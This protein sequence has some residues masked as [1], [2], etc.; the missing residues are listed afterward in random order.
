MF[1]SPGHRIQKYL[2]KHPETKVILV[3]GS[4]G[5]TSAI[6]AITSILTKS[7]NVSIGINKNISPDIVVLDFR[8]MQNFPLIKPDFV[9]LTSCYSK[10]ELEYYKPWIQESKYLFYNFNDIDKEVK[11]ELSQ[12]QNSFTYGDERPANFYFENQDSSLHGFKGSFVDPEDDRIA[13]FV[14]LLGE[15]NLR[16]VSLAAGIARSFKIPREDIIK[17]IESLRPLRGRM[18]PAEGPN[19]STIIDDSA[20]L[21]SISIKNGVHTISMLPAASRIVVIKNIR[22]K[23]PYDPDLIH[24]IVIIDPDI[25]VPENG[26]FH[27]FKTEIEAIK[28]IKENAEP[29]SIILLE[30]PLPELITHYTL[31]D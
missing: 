30:C 16:P 26:I 4:R 22:R 8:S 25:S 9:A 21:S 3:M 6:R 28:Y 14:H 29:D 5:I 10:K 13:V 11:K 7:F 15:H 2:K 24:S 27:N 23:V 12:H 18:S 31:E 19:G 17:A 20:D 1:L